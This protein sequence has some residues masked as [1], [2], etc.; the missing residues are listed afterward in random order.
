MQI[1]KVTNG[2]IEQRTLIPKLQ[3]LSQRTATLEA[4]VQRAEGKVERL[5]EGSIPEFLG[6]SFVV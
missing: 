3:S 6:K 1:A 2:Q 5:E 4:K